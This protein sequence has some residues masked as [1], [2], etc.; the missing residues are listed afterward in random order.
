MS[1]SNE[2]HQGNESKHSR[3]FFHQTVMENSTSTNKT[4][5][6]ISQDIKQVTSNVS[7]NTINSDKAFLL[8]DLNDLSKNHVSPAYMKVPTDPIYDNTVDSSFDDVT[9]NNKVFRPLL[10]AND[11]VNI[12]LHKSQ[13]LLN[14][15][16]NSPISNN[17]PILTNSP[18]NRKDLRDLPCSLKQPSKLVNDTVRTFFINTKKKKKKKNTTK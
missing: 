5:P 17:T 7:C 12:Q 9:V 8:N 11:T 14:F 4:E 10:D 2:K 15:D 3:P 18:F 13:I 16:D 1:R 6:S